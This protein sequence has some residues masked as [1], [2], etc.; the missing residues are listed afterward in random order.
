MD[1]YNLLVYIKSKALHCY[2]R[3]IIPSN[4]GWVFQNMKAQQPPSDLY[5]KV[6]YLAAFIHSKGKITMSV[7][8][9]NII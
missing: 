4:P 2:Y 1:L 3:L 6:P 9:K 7:T 8:Q 5:L